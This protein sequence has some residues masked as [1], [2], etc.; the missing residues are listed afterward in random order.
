MLRRIVGGSVPWRP[1]GE[2]LVEIQHSFHGTLVQHA[3]DVRLARALSL[4]TW[5]TWGMDYYVYLFGSILTVPFA[6]T[7]MLG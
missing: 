2:S 4:Y 1:S 6:Q 5:V 3:L 7:Q